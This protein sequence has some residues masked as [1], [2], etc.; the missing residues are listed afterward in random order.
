VKLVLAAFGRM[1]S[2]EL[3]AAAAEYHKRLGK[4]CA[5]ERLEVR[6]ERGD[7][8]AARR[9]EAAR[10]IEGLRPGDFLVLCDQRGRQPDTRGLADF[11]AERERAGPGRTVFL[12]GGPYGV[13]DSLRER[14][15]LVLG[16]SRLTLPHELARLVL[17]EALY[18]A[19]SLLRG[20]KYHHG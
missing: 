2:G 5:L 11:L 17:S 9:R 1:R 20:E 7:S 10:F 3:A 13:D 19:F 8:A 4:Y 18:R 6:E 15:G 14:A 16:L 12:V